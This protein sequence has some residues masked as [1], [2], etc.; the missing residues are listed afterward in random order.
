MKR[1]TRFLLNPIFPAVCAMVFLAVH[2]VR[3]DAGPQYRD[4]K[5]QATGLTGTASATG[6]SAL[7]QN[8]AGLTGA[9]DWGF[10]LSGDI[11][12]NSVLLDYADWAAKNYKNLDSIGALMKNIGPVDNKWAPFSNSFVLN[13]QYDEYAFAI[14]EDLRY[15]LTISKAVMT[16]VLGVGALSDLIV[17]GGRGFEGPAGYRFGVAAKYIYRLR[18]DDRLIGTGDNV[19]Y[20]V[21][22]KLNQPSNGILD[23]ISK[24]KVAGDIAKTQQGVGLNLGA[25]KDLSKNWT[26]GL[27]LN[28]FPTIMDA[29]F[30]RPEV[31]VGVTYH[32]IMELIPDL[33]IQK[34]WVNLDIHHFLIPGTP[35]FKQLKLGAGYEAYL[36]NRPV[37]F[38]GVGLN[39]GYPTF[40]V[41]FGY[42]AYLSYTYVSQEVGTFPGQ[43]QLSFHKLAVDVQF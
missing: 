9:K 24:V 36:G 15:D 42:I 8:P 26:A 4:L 17:I 43:E 34:C 28:D 23:D 10:G 2:P 33:D 22:N 1:T 30:V 31:N 21:K 32:R 5:S 40:G 25:E 27:A 12:L 3:A 39:D 11:G 19:F 16:P 38:V 37:G 13:G 41:R 18:F 35:W 29:E 20:T 6:W 7:F 14:V